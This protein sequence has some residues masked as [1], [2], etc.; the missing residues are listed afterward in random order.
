[1]F[2]KS[3]VFVITAMLMSSYSPSF[4]KTQE[5]LLKNADSEVIGES[6]TEAA[7]AE[8][9][10]QKLIKEF[11]P[12]GFTTDELK[13]IVKVAG[14]DMEKLAKAISALYP[15]VDE[16]IAKAVLEA[17]KLKENAILALT[18]GEEMKKEDSTA[19]STD[20]ATAASSEAASSGSSGKVCSL[21]Q[22]SHDAFVKAWGSCSQC[23]KVKKQ[24]ETAAT[25][26]TTA[27]ADAKSG[28]GVCDYCGAMTCKRNNDVCDACYKKGIT[29][30]E[31]GSSDNTGSSSGDTG[32]S[33]T[34]GSCVFGSGDSGTTSSPNSD[35]SGAKQFQDTTSSKSIF[36]SGSNLKSDETGV[37][38]S[39]SDPASDVR[40]N[41]LSLLGLSL[42]PQL[43]NAGMDDDFESLVSKIVADYNADALS[44]VMSKQPTFKVNF[45]K[46]QT[47]IDKIKKAVADNPNA[48]KDANNAVQQ[49]DVN[50]LQKVKN[51][52]VSAQSFNKVKVSN[53]YISSY[54]D[55]TSMAELIKSNMPADVATSIGTNKT[56][57]KAIFSAISYK[58]LMEKYSGDDKDKVLSCL[59]QMSESQ[60]MGLFGGGRFQATFRSYGK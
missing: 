49:T 17:Y 2:K 43:M 34:G 11:A 23:D 6:S 28:D 12:D 46:Y 60:R 56:Q 53:N 19:K 48:G 7:T 30:S 39:S 20:T 54:A 31:T 5:E 36:D 18:D 8:D 35:V 32:S 13:Q 10:I 14:G 16:T 29:G 59:S 55:T 37:S 27:L 1:M 22:S 25:S 45:S 15:N 44:C 41:V 26:G 51:M 58:I 21:P 3:I 52:G 57:G 24:K 42:N 47:E 4:A 50:A 9:P 40:K 38:V 33:G